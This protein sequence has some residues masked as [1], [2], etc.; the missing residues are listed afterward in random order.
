MA[1]FGGQQ[2]L[3]GGLRVYT[4]YDPEMQCAGEKRRSRRAI[5]QIGKTRKS[6]RDLEG[7][8]VAI[9]PVVG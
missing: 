7:S 9:D 5:E 4:G 8:L 3:R 2:V 1:R 6:S